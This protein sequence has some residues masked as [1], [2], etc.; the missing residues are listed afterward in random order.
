MADDIKK[1]GEK[2]LDAQPHGRVHR[3]AEKTLTDTLNNK[4]ERPP[5]RADAYDF[6]TKPG[7]TRSRQGEE[8][9]RTFE[10][11]D[12]P[13]NREIMDEVLKRRKA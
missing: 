2:F 13:I 4:N 12:A 3:E 1:V 9:V 7:A 11:K 8:E 5:T 6:L 10:E